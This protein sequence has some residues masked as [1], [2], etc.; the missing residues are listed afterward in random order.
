MSLDTSTASGVTASA[1]DGLT[2]TGS[3]SGTKDLPAYTSTASNNVKYF[4]GIPIY[5]PLAIAVTG[6]VLYPIY[7]DQGYPS[8]EMCEVD[9]C[10]AHAGIGLD[11]H[12]H[13]DPYHHTPGKC[14]YSPKD[15]TDPVYGH[16]PLIAY[17]LDGYKVY[18]RHLNE[19]NIGYTTAL[20]DCGGH[21]HG[22]GIYSTYHY[23]AQVQEFS[24]LA[25]SILSGK[26]TTGT[27]YYGHIPGVFKCWR[28][29]IGTSRLFGAQGN[30]I[31]K[32]D[33]RP[34]FEDIKACATILS[35]VVITGTA[36]QFT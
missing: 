32:L 24:S 16:P 3:H 33:N 12:Y 2:V 14:M 18:G 35:T 20:D 1:T 26:A 31:P 25:N 9:M 29:D 28:G 21:S 23:H 4:P 11:Y 27:A 17:A 22:T 30:S 5:G 10:N 36:G 8:Q 15:Y 13:G 7:D 19:T 6:Q 34:D